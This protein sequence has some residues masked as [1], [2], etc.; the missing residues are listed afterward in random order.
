M[1]Q[2]VG[3]CGG[4]AF[5]IPIDESRYGAKFLNQ[6]VQGGSHIYHHTFHMFSKQGVQAEPVDLEVSFGKGEYFWTNAFPT[7]LVD[8]HQKEIKRF[9][10]AVKFMRALEVF[11][12]II[13]IK[14]SLKMFMFSDEF[15]ERMIYPR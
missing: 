12:A 7:Q 14:V 2:A 10:W 11:F 13:P 3:Y 15:I 9:K 8:K 6:G 4:Q 5:S 1:F